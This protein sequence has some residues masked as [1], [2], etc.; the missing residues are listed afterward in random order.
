M[1]ARHFDKHTDN[2]E[3]RQNVLF[4]APAFQ[5][6]L[7]SFQEHLHMKLKHATFTHCLGLGQISQTLALPGLERP[8]SDRLLR[9]SGKVS[10]AD[11]LL[12]S[13]KLCPLCPQLP[14]TKGQHQRWPDFRF[15]QADQFYR[16]KLV[17]CND[18][19]GSCTM[20][21]CVSK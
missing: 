9:S 20:S 19:F 14:E 13:W 7:L 21:G 3:T 16:L 18:K 8:C 1:A 10:L 5:R 15:D 2:K 6:K 4:A 11:N 17:T 12:N